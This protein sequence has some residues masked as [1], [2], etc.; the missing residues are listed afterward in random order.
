[1]KTIDTENPPRGPLSVLLIGPPGGRKTTLML[2]FPD[3][4]VIDCDLNLDGPTRYLKS[5]NALRPYKMD[6]V[7]LEDGRPVDPHQCFDRLLDLVDEVKNDPSIRWCGIDSLTHVN[8][9]IIRKVLYEQKNSSLMEPHFWAPF[10]THLLNLLIAKIRGSG[11]HFLVLVHES[12]TDEPAS[13][14]KF[15]MAKRITG[16]QPTIQGGV[17]KFFGG[18]FTDMWR[19]STER[20]PGGL[21]GVLETERT[22]LDNLKNSLGLPERI[23][24]PTYAKI[25]PYLERAGYIV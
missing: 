4:A 5:I 15:T 1:M 17:A 21:L 25:A 18:F 11:K 14:T 8:E 10:K 3:L 20:A 9:F 13:G 16:R 2:Q 12:W 6:T 23:E 22:A 7:G 19:A 24:E